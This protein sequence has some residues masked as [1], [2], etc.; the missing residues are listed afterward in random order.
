MD[1]MDLFGYS[2]I[3]GHFPTKSRILVG[4]IKKDS[5]IEEDIDQLLKYVDWVKDEY[6]YGDYSMIDAFLVTYDF[7][8]D[9][10]RHKQSVGSRKYTIGV[11]PAHSSEWSNISLVKYVFN[12]EE[13]KISFRLIE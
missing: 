12:P 10:I 2:Y 9:V 7:P 11:R 8:E 4:E 5:A 3:P 1:K 13:G 6:C